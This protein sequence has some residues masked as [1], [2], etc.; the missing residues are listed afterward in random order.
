MR[1]AKFL[2][3]DKTPIKLR[4]GGKVESIHQNEII[5][6]D[7]D[8]YKDIWGFRFLGFFLPETDSITNVERAYQSNNTGVEVVVE[9]VETESSLEEPVEEPVEEVSSADETKDILEEVKSLDNKQLFVIKKDKMYEYM[10]KLGIDYSSISENRN[11][12]LSFFKK[13]IKEL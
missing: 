1:L 2:R 3:T 4:V 7:Y 11:D 13:K 6:A 5:I 12:V 8:V 10:D 9:E